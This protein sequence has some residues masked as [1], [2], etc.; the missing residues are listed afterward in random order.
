IGRARSGA[1]LQRR[2]AIA[3]GQPRT[4]SGAILSQSYRTKPAVRRSA[5]Q[6]GPRAGS[7]GQGRGSETVLAASGGSEAG[8]GG[9]VLLGNPEFRIQKGTR[10]S[11]EF[12]LLNS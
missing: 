6:S 10:S 12:W 8:A 9:E 5:P 3:T 11:S 2:R 7:P 1:E 4:G